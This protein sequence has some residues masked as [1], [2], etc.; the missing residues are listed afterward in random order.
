MTLTTEP[1]TYKKAEAYYPPLLSRAPAITVSTPSPSIPT[2]RPSRAPN[3]M[4]VVSNTPQFLP[5]AHTPAVEAT[6]PL[7]EIPASEGSST[8]ATSDSISTMDIPLAG[9]N[10]LPDTF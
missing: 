9:S 8:S 4:A 10:R 2:A 7:F 6:E 1:S 3:P 5:A